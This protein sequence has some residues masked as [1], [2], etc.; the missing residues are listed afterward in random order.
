[1]RLMMATASSRKRI[2]TIMS[3]IQRPSALRSGVTIDR[4]GA[5]SVKRRRYCRCADLGVARNR[6]ARRR[7]PARATLGVA[8]VEPFEDQHQICGF[9]LLAPKGTTF[10]E[11]VSKSPALEPLAPQREPVAIPIDDPHAVRS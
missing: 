2:E 8:K 6:R 3:W 10:V 9:D 1:M 7:N 5:G 11:G 4:Y